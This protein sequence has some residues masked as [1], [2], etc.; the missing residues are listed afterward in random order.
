[1]D[2]LERKT[3]IQIQT[4]WRRHTT[5]GQSF[6]TLLRHNALN[7]RENKDTQR[8]Q[9]VLLLPLMLL[10][11]SIHTDRQ[12]TSTPSAPMWNVTVSLSNLFSFIYNNNFICN[13]VMKSENQFWV[14]DDSTEQVVF[15]KFIR[16]I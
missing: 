14:S 1:M 6:C 10:V 12:T 8:E 15:I 5:V 9:Q 2:K 7:K 3:D 13:K 4:G 16:T 11:G